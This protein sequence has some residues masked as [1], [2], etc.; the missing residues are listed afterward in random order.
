MSY[1]LFLSLNVLG[2]ICFGWFVLGPVV[3]RSFVLAAVA[4][5]AWVLLIHEAQKVLVQ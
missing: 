2:S 3:R 5:F 1:A 4:L